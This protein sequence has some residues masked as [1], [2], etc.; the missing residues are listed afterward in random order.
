MGLDKWIGFEC[1]WEAAWIIRNGEYDEQWAMIPSAK[2]MN[3]N[4]DKWPPFAWVPFC[5]LGLDI[6]SIMKLAGIP[7]LAGENK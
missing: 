3:E 4:P 6:A 7:I 1:E 5:D 2:W